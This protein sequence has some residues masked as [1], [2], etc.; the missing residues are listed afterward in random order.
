[1]PRAIWRGFLRLSLVTCPIYLSPAT[2]RT[3]PIRLHQVWQPAPVDVDEDELPDRNAG[4][5]GSALLAPQ[6]AADAKPDADQSRAATRIAL[7]PHDPGTGEEIDKREI[8]KGYEYGRGQFV[9]FTP[10]E[11]KALDVES[12]KVIDLEKFVLRADLDPV[13]FDSSYY[14]YPDGPIAVEMLR[15]IGAAMAEAGVV[16]LGRLTLIR[17]ER[18]VVVEPR[19]TGMALFT[20][21][22]AEEV[23]ATQFGMAEGELDAEMVAI[24]E[25]IIAQRTGSF[26]PTT[27]RDRYQEALREL[28]EA[29][30]KG[31]TVKPK[32]IAAPPPVID[33]M[34]ALKRSLAREASGS[35]HTA[36]KKT[37][38]TAPD[39]RQP[40]LLLPVPGGRKRKTQAAEEPTTPAARRRKRA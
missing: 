28:I 16:G 37:K 3:K 39:R 6:L 22:A 2:T 30:M 14:L 11:L 10:E 25:A 4:Q 31:L 9:T 27:H 5:Q 24:A 36:P 29:K 40:A 34:D 26:E 1:M 20:L 35:K 32:E 18:M 21:R 7:R 13:Y 8:V 38:K 33:L 23:R 12:S 19:G 17:R 15:V